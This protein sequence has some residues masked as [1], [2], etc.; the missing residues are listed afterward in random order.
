MGGLGRVFSACVISIC[1]GNATSAFGETAGTK[2]PVAPNPTLP[3]YTLAPD[4]CHKIPGD[5][6]FCELVPE[7]GMGLGSINV[8]VP[9]ANLKALQQVK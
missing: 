7:A 1:L 8:M 3:T 6:H 4:R 5:G 9:R 2:P